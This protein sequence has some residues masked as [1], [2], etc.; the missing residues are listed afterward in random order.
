MR[1]QV[2][3]RGVAHRS[4]T[5]AKTGKPYAFTEVHF[6]YEDDYI[7]GE[8]CA[9][10]TV[11]QSAIPYPLVVGDNVDMVFHFANGRCFIDAVL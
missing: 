5:S 3:I 9:N 10:A 2:N 11:D 1:K 7:T 6:T 4:G 8:K